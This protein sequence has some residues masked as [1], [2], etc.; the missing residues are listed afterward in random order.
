MS[1]LKVRLGDREEHVVIGVG[2][3]HENDGGRTVAALCN[4]LKRKMVTC[5][6]ETNMTFY[7]TVSITVRSC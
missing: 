7:T 3:T 6:D 1:I 5:C 4:H 2:L